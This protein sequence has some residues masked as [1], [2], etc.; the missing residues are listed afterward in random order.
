MRWQ[1]LLLDGWFFELI[2]VIIESGWELI[3][4]LRC[5]IVFWKMSL[6]AFLAVNQRVYCHFLCPIGRSAGPG[7][8]ILG[9]M[10]SIF[11]MRIL[12]CYKIS[13]FQGRQ[14]S[15]DVKTTNQA[16]WDSPNTGLTRIKLQVRYPDFLLRLRQKCWLVFSLII[17]RTSTG[18]LLDRRLRVGLLI[19]I[20][21]SPST[22]PSLA[23]SYTAGRSLW[24]WRVWM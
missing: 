16:W 21:L 9:R 22:S 23:L 17:G 11:R 14:T 1:I 2:L 3:W 15:I 18:R 20:Y 19:T 8:Y 13:F 10:P 12:Y 5:I 7:W 24:R 4:L 6:L